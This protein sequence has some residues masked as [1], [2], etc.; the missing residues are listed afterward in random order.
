MSRLY[1]V[2]HGRAVPHGTPGLDDNDRPLTA[3]GAARFTRVALGL[4]RLGVEPVRIVS[5]PLPRARRTAEIAAE[6]L[7][8]GHAL[9]FDD[10]LAQGRSAGSIRDWLRGLSGESLMIVGHDPA[11]SG[12]LALLVGADPSAGP[13]AMKKGGVAE[14]ES[15]GGDAYR[16]NWLATPRLFAR[17]SRD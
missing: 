6:A 5:S 4:S 9:V 11:F 16:L 14:L 7:G 1:L 8:L 17:L 15:D 3:G 10:A 13:F 2:R 12:L